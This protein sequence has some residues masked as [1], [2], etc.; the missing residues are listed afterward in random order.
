[1][2]SVAHLIIDDYPIFYSKNSFYEDV[3]GL[4]FLAEDFIEYK[5]KANERN[6][7][8]WGNTYDND[9]TEELSIT[10][11]RTTVSICMERLEAYGVSHEKC[12]EEFQE[13]IKIMKD[14]EFYNFFKTENISYE[15]YLHLVTEILN[16][17]YTE[18]KNPYSSFKDY[19]VDSDLTLE[20]Q[21]LECGLYSILSTRSPEAIV[22]YDI[23]DLVQGGWTNEDPTEQIKTKKI[24]VFTEGKTDTEFLKLGLNVF[25]PHL[26]NLYHFID[27]DESRYEANASML[28]HSIKSFVGSGVDNLIVALFDNDSAGHKEI[29]NLRNVKLPENIKVL[30]YPSCELL[31]RYPTIGPTGSAEMDVNGLAGSIEM[32]LGVDC[33]SDNSGLIPIKWTGYVESINKY[34]GSILKKKEI[35]NRFRDKMH[36]AKNEGNYQIWQEIELLLNTLINAFK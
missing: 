14:D 23:D 36:K 29:Y 11:F 24:I 19:L 18:T 3:A 9:D 30:T 34:Q 25:K 21:S 31:E 1:M 2:G 4:I 13:K 35:Q 10:N 28:V 15:S 7:I 20:Y 5:I 17:K 33:I 8:I 16:T 27:F 6:Q 26:L 22:E 32:Y 12:K